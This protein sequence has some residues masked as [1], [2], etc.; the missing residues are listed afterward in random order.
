MPTNVVKHIIPIMQVT[1]FI[2]SPMLYNSLSLLHTQT[3]K[4][5]TFPSGISSRSTLSLLLEKC[6]SLSPASHLPTLRS[7]VVVISLNKRIFSHYQLF[8]VCVHCICVVLLRHS[9][10][11]IIITDHCMCC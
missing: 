10:F 5:M 3:L 8:A 11:V 2:C 9:L 1:A 7:A 4:R 6:S